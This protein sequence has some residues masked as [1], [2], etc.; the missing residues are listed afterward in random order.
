MADITP[1]D[2]SFIH[3]MHVERVENINNCLL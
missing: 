3:C 2:T 1:A